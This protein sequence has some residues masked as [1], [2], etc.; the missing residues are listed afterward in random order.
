MSKIFFNQTSA[1]SQITD[2]QK[3]TSKAQSDIVDRVF[4]S[5][6]LEDHPKG[7]NR[8]DA[9]T[10]PDSP[11][12]LGRPKG[13]AKGYTLE[14]REQRRK[15]GKEILDMLGIGMRYDEIAR[16]PSINLEPG[17][18]REIARYWQEKRGLS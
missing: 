6:H 17:Q 7:I 9:P 15:R 4:Y 11:K 5:A 10:D 12:K 14:E 8:Y 16:Q 3:R 18:V 2:K 1:P 13:G